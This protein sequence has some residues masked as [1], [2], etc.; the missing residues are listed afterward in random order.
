MD[1]R[2]N[3]SLVKSLFVHQRGKVHTYIVKYYKVK[4]DGKVQHFK[5]GQKL[6]PKGSQVIS[7]KK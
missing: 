4:N 2:T 3:N 5:N 6:E 1:T 7:R